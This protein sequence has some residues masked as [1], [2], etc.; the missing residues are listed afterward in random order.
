MHEMH[1]VFRLFLSPPTTEKM[2]LINVALM[3]DHLS[4]TSRGLSELSVP[5]RTS[6]AGM[7][8]V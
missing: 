1:P 3:G 2:T 5:F 6:S 7:L 8:H 4:I